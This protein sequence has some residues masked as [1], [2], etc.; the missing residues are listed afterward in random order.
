MQE[1]WYLTNKISRKRQK[2]RREE[3][4]KNSKLNIP[5]LENIL[6]QTERGPLRVQEN[7]K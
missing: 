6:F 5:R 1:V 2:R 3:L 4:V 7:K